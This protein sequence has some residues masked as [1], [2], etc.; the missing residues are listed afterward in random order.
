MFR[1][2]KVE[3][4]GAT[5]LI[6]SPNGDP[7]VTINK[8]GKGSVVF[9][10]APDLLG[11]DERVTP[12][13]AHMLAH[14]FA[15]ATPIKVSGDVEYLINRTNTSWVVT[16]INNNGVNKP[17]Q[18]LA[19]VDRNAVVTATVSIPGQQIRSAI[20]WITD[21]PLK[22]HNHANAV[23]LTLNPGGIAIVELK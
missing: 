3:L 16:L 17:Q 19:T 18:G 14:A 20:E 23:S 7:L 12:F 21:K 11:I 22:V 1:Y 13:A 2:E 15:D 6:S 10:A 5:A 4:K 8:L 9:N